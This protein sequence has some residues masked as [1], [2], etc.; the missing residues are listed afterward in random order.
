VSRTYVSEVERGW[1]PPVHRQEQL[2][3]VL[4]VERADLFPNEQDAPG[5]GRLVEAADAGGTHKAT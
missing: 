3:A 4:G 5:R 2:A 1:V